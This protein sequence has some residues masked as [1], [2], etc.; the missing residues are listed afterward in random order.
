MAT[1]ATILEAKQKFQV[2]FPRVSIGISGSKND[3]Y[4]VSRVRSEADA[5]NIPRDFEGVTIQV[6]V[7]D[8][9]SKS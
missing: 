2:K 9:I 5:K 3:Y 7:I 4:L 6:K 1:L 8:H